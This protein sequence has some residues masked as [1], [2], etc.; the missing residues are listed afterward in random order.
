MLSVFLM[1]FYVGGETRESLQMKAAEV[2]NLAA[3]VKQGRK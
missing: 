3:Q 2:Q 1:H